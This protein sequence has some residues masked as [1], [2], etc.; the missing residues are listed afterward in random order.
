MIRPQ[1]ILA[2][3]LMGAT[4]SRAFNFTYS[5]SGNA[6]HWSFVTPDSSVS[7]NSFNT[8]THAV[9]F[10]IAAD[11]FSATN[12]TAEINAVRNCF[13]QWG[14]IFNSLIKFEEAGLV[15]PGY[16]V[17][18]SDHSN[19]VYWAKSSTLVNGGLNDI[20]GS[21]GV[22]FTSVSV[23]GNVILDYDIV[24]NAV[25]KAWF[26][27]FNDKANTNIF[28]EGT[29]CH[30]IGHSLGLSHSAIGGATMLWA[31]QGGVDTQA[32]L[33]LDELAFAYALYSSGNFQTNFAT[34]QGTVSKNGSPILGAAVIIEGTNGNLTSGTLTLVNGAYLLQSLPP[35]SY[36]VRVFPLDPAGATR[37]LIKG[38]NING[39]NFNTADTSFLPTTNVPV[40]LSAGATNTLNLV[41]INA[42]PAFRITRILKPV[43]NPPESFSANSLPIILSPGQSDYTIGVFSENLPTNNVS[44]TITGNGLTLTGS[45]VYSNNLF[46]GLSG[47]TVSVGVASNATPGLRTFI[48]TQGT[49]VAYANGYLEISPTVS[50]YNFDGLDDVF[51]RQY[52]FPF[53]ATNG[54]PDADPDGDG[55]NNFAESVAGTIPTNAAS[56]LKMLNVVVAGNG[57]TSVWQSVVGKRYQVSANTNLAISAW[58]NVGSVVTAAGT[59]SQ[60][61]DTTATNTSRFYRV[62]VLP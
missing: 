30:E 19:V 58:Q 11:G 51:Q 39:T 56:L 1:I 46:T 34:L 32:G 13:G 43:A 23:P 49:N 61:L 31:G 54:S 55:M 3:L 17:N 26:T 42:E 4:S 45:T 53:T 6:K 28:V 22:T 7:T 50:D 12:T 36:N 29:L 44:L 18:T 9:R 15:S 2:L 52:F 8:N 14:S 10:Y 57:T 35:G 47:M 59:N 20:S 5:S 24:L 16:D 33:S 62:Q 40:S 60:I 38:A 27:D 37:S 41:V 21:L 25:Q 48:Y